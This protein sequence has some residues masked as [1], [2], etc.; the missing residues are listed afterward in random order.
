MGN[1]KLKIASFFIICTLFLSSLC[2]LS[3]K[4][5]ELTETEAK[6][7]IIK[8]IIKASFTK[9][10]ERYGL[11]NKINA[12]NDDEQRYMGL[13]DKGFLIIK[14]I[15]GVKGEKGVYLLDFAEKAAPDIEKKDDKEDESYLS[16]AKVKRFEVKDIKKISD[17]EFKAE[18]YVGYRLTPFGEILLG[19]GV[20]VER[21]E[22]AL[23]KAT[24][25][26]WRIK[27]K[28]NF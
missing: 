13:E 16:L 15:S 2:P 27:F 1:F 10:L 25:D 7:L 14:E 22:D 9:E 19:K 24:D 17:S 6:D 5:D 21:K 20:E 18:V 26:G 8:E 4:A 11:S 3:V 28:T 23:I 12:Q